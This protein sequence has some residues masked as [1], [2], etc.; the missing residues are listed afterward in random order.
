[1]KFYSIMFNFGLLW[2][3]SMLR[4]YSSQFPA[5]ISDFVCENSNVHRNVLLK[6]TAI[7]KQE[8]VEKLKYCDFSLWNKD[9]GHILHIDIPYLFCLQLFPFSGSI[10]EN[11]KETKRQ[12]TIKGM[13]KIDSYY[14]YPFRNFEIDFP[15]FSILI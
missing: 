9:F 14:F 13:R 4:F 10:D 15:A 12:A 8:D 5:F 1:M 7:W 6:T 11:L 2:F 3:H